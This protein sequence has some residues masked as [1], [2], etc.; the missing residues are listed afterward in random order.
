M[1]G[2]V[3]SENRPDNGQ[4]SRTRVGDDGRV[5]LIFLVNLISRFPASLGLG[6]SKILIVADQESLNANNAEI[7]Q[8]AKANNKIHQKTL[9]NIFSAGRI[10]VW[11]KIYNS[12]NFRH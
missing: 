12:L 8:G 6:V 10:C 5:R 3:V 7:G 1:N 4:A 11:P 9:D 2:I